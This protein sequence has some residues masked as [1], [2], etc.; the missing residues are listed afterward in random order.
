MKNSYGRFAAMIGTSSVLM[1][2]LMYLHTYELG[3]VRFSETRLF[4]TLIMAGAMAV[5]MLGFMSPMYKK[6]GL[7]IGIYVGAA[8]VLIVSLW[9]MR[10]QV[11]VSDASYMRAMI[12]HHSIAILTSE[13]V[14]FE[15]ARVRQLA[16]DIVEAQRREIKEM[17]W[18]LQDIRAH[19]YA[20][21]ADQATARPVP[22]FDVEP[23]SS[24]R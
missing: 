11:T 17:N 1:F 16:A 14:D 3:H 5:V 23:R 15:D 21:T 8:V 4:M 20:S 24:T 19:G 13:R 22:Q 7:N 9:L 10:S 18:L 2:G 12:P 6:V